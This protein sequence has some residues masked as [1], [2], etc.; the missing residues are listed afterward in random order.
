MPFLAISAVTN[1]A[2][3]TT[4]INGN[5]GGGAAASVTGFPPG[6]VSNGTI[7]IDDPTTYQANLDLIQ[8]AAGLAGMAS[9]ANETGTDLGTLILPP[10]VYTFASTAALDGTLTLNAKGESN[11]VWVFQI[12][13]TLIASQNSAVVIENL[14]PGGGSGDGIFW[15]AGTGITIGPDSTILGNYLAGT[16]IT[17]GGTTSGNGRALARAAVTLDDTN[18][19]DPDGGPPEGNDW[20]GGVMYNANGQVVPFIIPEPAALLWLMP[21]GALGLVLWRRQLVA[22]R[23]I[24]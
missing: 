2:G 13:T 20:D 23:K 24:A 9:T 18:I 14:G 11:A 4:I 21:L 10:G 5:V 12:G 6:V 7:Y 22:K 15:N 17:F 8:A 1:T 3:A 16:S 19:L